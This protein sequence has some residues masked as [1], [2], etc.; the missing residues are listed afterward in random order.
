MHNKKHT[1]SSTFL[2]INGIIFLNN[3]SAFASN[4]DPTTLPEQILN[5]LN[6]GG[7]IMWIMLAASVIGLS[8]AIERIFSLRLKN[9]FNKN[10]SETVIDKLLV[11]NKNEIINSLHQDQTLIATALKGILIR[12]SGTR[13]EIE[14]GLE[15][16]LARA[17]WDERKNIKP[18]GLVASIA[19]LL[20][21]L[22]TVIGMIDAFKQASINGMN[23]P[24]IFA[25]GIYQALY[26]TAF[27]LILSIPFL[28]LHNY[29]KTKSELIIRKIED[30]SL[31][32]VDKLLCCNNDTITKEENTAA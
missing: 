30:E 8:Y 32:F 21:L 15:D 19:P 22:G 20:G 28:I 9:H 2:I 5:L 14:H 4:S 26:T 31:I 6:N 12:S 10:L 7:G 18:I 25:A 3:S 11:H 16:D 23:D 27:G 24:A 1:I 17:L 13:E 29:L